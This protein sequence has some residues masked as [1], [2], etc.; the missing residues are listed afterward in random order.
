MSGME[1]YMIEGQPNRFF[2]ERIEPGS[3]AEKIG[4]LPGAELL[5]LNFKA[6]HSLDLQSMVQLLKAGNG[7][8]VLL[9]IAQEEEIIYKV[10]TLKK[11]I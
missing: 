7:K 8:N 11:R 9:K 4:I 2:I 5:E 6:A 1:I 3:P 10:L